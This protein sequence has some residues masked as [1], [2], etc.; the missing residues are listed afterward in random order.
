M[1]QTEVCSSVLTLFRKSQKRNFFFIY[2][3]VVVIKVMKFEKWI[4][5]WTAN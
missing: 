2:L 4:D 5:V 1:K 3:K